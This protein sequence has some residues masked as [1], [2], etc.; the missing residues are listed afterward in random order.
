MYIYNLYIF[1]CVLQ[2]KHVGAG[3]GMYKGKQLFYCKKDYAIFVPLETVLHEKD[4]DAI[5]YDE[6]NDQEK[7]SQEEDTRRMVQSCRD[8][9]T[10]RS[11]VYD[12]SR[13][14][15]TYTVFNNFV[16]WRQLS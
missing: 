4:F 12:N 9:A 13:T 6:Q 16:F 2:D 15:G 8:E 11:L 10:A 3:T 14:K 5:S 1:L 7:L